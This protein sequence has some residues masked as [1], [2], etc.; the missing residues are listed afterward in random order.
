MSDFIDAYL[1]ARNRGSGVG[2][3]PAQTSSTPQTTPSGQQKVIDSPTTPGCQPAPNLGGTT[4]A[5]S[6]PNTSSAPSNVETPQ[7]VT[8]STDWMG[9]GHN[10]NEACEEGIRE[11]QSRFPN[12]VLSR[13]SSDE[14]VRKDIF[15]HVEYKYYCTIAVK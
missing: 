5:P 14:A 10:Q 3:A 2:Q 11:N 1:A 4:N 8:Y 13:V 12:K 7:I 6:S 9:G 15:G